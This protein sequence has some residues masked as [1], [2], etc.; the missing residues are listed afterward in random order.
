MYEDPFAKLT[1]IE[2]DMQEIGL[3]I[4]NEHREKIIN[5][6]ELVFHAAADVRFDESLR[7]VTKINVRGTRE[8]MLLSQQ[9]QNLDVLVYV[10]TAF[11]TPGLYV[12]EKCK[13]HADRKCFVG[14]S[15]TARFAKISEI[16]FLTLKLHESIRKHIHSHYS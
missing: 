3:G 9:I 13:I 1:L 4:S 15:A 2:G 12:K 5:E 8:I 6:V 7:E 14:R 16:L 11:C 10:S